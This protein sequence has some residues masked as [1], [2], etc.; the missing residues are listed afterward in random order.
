MNGVGI[1][2]VRAFER[3]EEAKQRVGRAF[4]PGAAARPGDIASGTAP[5]R[6]LDPLSVVAPEGAR[7][8]VRLRDGSDGYTFDGGFS[9]RDGALV[10]RNGDAV[11]GYARPGA[12][13]QALHIDAVDRA[14]HEVRNL[15]L[16]A[17]GALRYERELFNPRDGRTERESVLAGRVALARFPAG[18]RLR[19]VDARIERAPEGVAAHLGTPGE[20]GFAALTPHARARSAVSIDASL[21]RL[22]DAYLQLEALLAAHKA[23][24]SVAKTTMDLLK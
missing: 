13:L 1:D 24:G 10:D 19:A 12:P 9:L 20:R 17:D 6:T 23:Q 8:V 4:A 7:F 5:Q 15:R 21:T 11:L 22:Q 2:T 14:L 18:S 3:I 16:D